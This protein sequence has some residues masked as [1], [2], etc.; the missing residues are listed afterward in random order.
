MNGSASGRDMYI[1]LVTPEPGNPRHERADFARLT[2]ERMQHFIGKVGD[3]RDSI[4]DDHS[5]N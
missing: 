2:R 4:T 5:I 3:P 1:A